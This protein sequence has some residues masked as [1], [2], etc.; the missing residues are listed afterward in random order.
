MNASAPPALEFSMADQRWWWQIVES[1]MHAGKS[2]SKMSSVE[3]SKILSSLRIAFSVSIFPTSF[4]LSVCP[5][6]L[7]TLAAYQ[8]ACAT[9]ELAQVD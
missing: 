8:R 9:A 5:S 1:D 6:C 4:S 2:K 3:L 7:A